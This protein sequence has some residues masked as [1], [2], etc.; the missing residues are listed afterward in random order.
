VCGGIAMKYADGL[1]NAGAS[2][3]VFAAFG[4]GAALQTVAMRTGTLSVAYVIVLGLESILAV[5]AGR[6]LL[7]ESVSLRSAAGI[8]II[9]LGMI[10]IKS[11]S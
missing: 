7:Q 9:I 10:L 3:L 11:P 1:R 6:L 5:A 2:L 8:V 4:A